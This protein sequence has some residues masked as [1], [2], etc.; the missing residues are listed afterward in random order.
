MAVLAV[1]LV[2]IGRWAAKRWNSV[3][4]YYEQETEQPP[5]I[6]DHHLNKGPSL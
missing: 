3:S 2:G 1:A 6:V 4:D 5:L